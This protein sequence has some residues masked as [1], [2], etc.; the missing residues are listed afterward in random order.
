MR[1]KGKSG[2]KD[3]GTKH[4]K[5]IAKAGGK[6]KMT[7]RERILAR[8]KKHETRGGSSILK[9]DVP[10]FSID[11]DKMKKFYKLDIIP[12]RVSVD[13]HPEAEKGELWHQRTIWVHY[14]ENEAGD[15]VPVLC[16]RKMQGKKCPACEEERRLSKD[17]DA[18]E[19]VL[20]SLRPRER[21]LYNLID[22]SDD[23]GEVKVW[24]ISY[25]NFGELLDE[26]IREGEDSDVASFATLEDG[27]TIK[28]RF[29]IKK[30]GKTK[31]P[32]ASKIDFID[33]EE[34]YDESILKKAFDLDKILKYL[35]YEEIEV[36]LHGG[37]GDDSDEDEDDTPKKGKKRH[38][39][40][41]EDDE[42]DDS[43]D[44]TEEDE[45][46]EEEDADEDSDSEE[47]DESDDDESE[48]DSE[49]DVGGE[50][51][52]DDEEEEA[53]DDE[54]EDSEDDEDDGDGEED[55]GDDDNED[56]EEDEKPKRE[57]KGKKCPA[58]GRFGKDCDK[59]KHCKR[60]KLWDE[61][62]DANS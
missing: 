37:D 12:Y 32:K 5:E 31:F 51:S 36:M 3:I 4:S 39:R 15:K 9:G 7:M 46:D 10:S 25:Y 52:D 59:L 34:P 47:S 35:S 16:L 21:E 61:C 62:D 49:D 58:G 38:K 42:D 1:T 24:D 20:K 13:N 48:D 8:S 53:S 2:E 6:K 45:D 50:D 19:D 30:M 56:E 40:D 29:S 57:A 41:E 27:K 26:E 60:C 17:E 22:L 55:D 33:R 14:L 23:D 44:D 11:T 18:D 43:D 28:V 54:D